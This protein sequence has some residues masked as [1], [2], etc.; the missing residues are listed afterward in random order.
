MWRLFLHDKQKGICPLCGTYISL[1]NE[2]GKD[3]SVLDHDHDTGRIRAVLHRS[4]NSAEGRILNFAD[5]RC[6][7]ED[8]K[9]FLVNMV[10]YWEADYSHHPFHPDHTI[11]EEDERLKLKRKLKNLKAAHAID[12]TK[13]RIAELSEIIKASIELVP[14]PSEWFKK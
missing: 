6:R 11:E 4:C 8:P 2:D 9:S 3:E 12:K 5:K 13:K 10:K 7:S 1:C 14:P